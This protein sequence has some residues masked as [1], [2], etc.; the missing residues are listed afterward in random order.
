[1]KNTESDIDIIAIDIKRMCSKINY[2]LK[3]SFS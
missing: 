3:I 2:K 1:M